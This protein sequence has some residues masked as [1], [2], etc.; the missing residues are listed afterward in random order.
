[1]LPGFGGGPD[2]PV[3]V[4]LAAAL[5]ARGVSSIRASLSRGR[6]SPGLERE[7]EEA[8]ELAESD[9]MIEAYVGRSFGG[10]VL[11]RLALTMFPRALVLLGY[12][13][14]S[15]SGVRRVEDEG[16]LELVGCPTLI[17]QGSR[18]PL[19][20]IRTFRRL[21]RTNERLE[22]HLLPGATHHFGRRQAEAVSTAAEWLVDK[23]S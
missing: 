22:L 17:V 5:R 1:M 7:V 16:V 12:P 14:R 23:L 19:G 3:L 21:A 2:Q 10:R 11:A 9:P 8:G 20:P 15:A 4:Q 6:V 13:V 18:D